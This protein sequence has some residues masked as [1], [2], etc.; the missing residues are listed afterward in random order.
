VSTAL[1]QPDR[2]AIRLDAVLGAL[3]DPLRRQ[4]VVELARSEEG[5]WR[6]CSTFGLPVS[7]A[8][9]THHFRV[10]RESGL[11]RMEDFGNR[12]LTSLRREDL[13]ARFPGLIDAIVVAAA[14]PD[15][16]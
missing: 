10:L 3:A 5:A 2:D 8:T 16:A 14:S 6:Q 13:E 7:K 12:R 11:V 4:V 1:P 15:R 9:R